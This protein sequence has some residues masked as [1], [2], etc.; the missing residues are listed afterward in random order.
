[1]F[2][3]ISI[4]DADSI[5]QF[6]PVERS[7][8]AVAVPFAA[9]EFYRANSNRFAWMVAEDTHLE[10]TV[11]NDTGLRAN[12]VTGNYFQALRIAPKWGRLLNE[13]D[14]WPGAPPVAVLGYAYWERH[15]A[16]DPAVVGRLFH[17][18]NQLVRIV[19][20]APYDF[21]GISPF[22]TAV[23]APAALLPLFF[24]GSPSLNDLSM[25]SR[26][27]YARLKPGVSMSAGAAQL[28][29]L[30]R[31]LDHRQ[32]GWVKPHERIV[33]WKLADLRGM[34]V[35]MILF[36]ILVLLILFSGCA[37]LGNLRLARGLARQ[38]EIDTRIAVGAGRF[39]VL[40]QLMTENLLLALL[41]SAAGLVLGTVAARWL[42]RLLDAPP[43][44]HIR[45][46]WEV[47]AVGALCIVISAFAFG[48]PAALRTVRR[49]HRRG[50]ARQVLV[51]VQVAVSCLLLIASGV[52]AHSLIIATSIDLAL[53]YRNMITVTAPGN[54][55]PVAA[56]EKL[57]ALSAILAALPAGHTL[58]AMLRQG[59]HRGSPREIRISKSRFGM[60]HLT[61]SHSTMSVAPARRKAT[62][63]DL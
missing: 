38:R 49:Y 5:V 39:R 23:W 40:R 6:A 53:D 1:M 36:P 11:E 29:S 10:L 57:D 19:G 17:I 63:S 12:F 18:N 55:S 47:V 26:G 7:G 3:R 59:S 37:N 4:R 62:T 24:E 45:I 52:L 46:D 61:R 54:L 13:Q 60:W 22:R 8:R 50:R 16:A 25:A 31:E 21:D 30:T 34:N 43:D 28:L 58:V 14:A 51:A 9:I 56:R 15:W 32:P 44:I 48:L 20:V 2:K 33:G 42:L 41:G 27:L 35:Q